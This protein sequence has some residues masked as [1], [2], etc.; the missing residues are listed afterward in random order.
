MPAPRKLP[1]PSEIR[2]LLDDG[3]SYAEI[4]EMYDCPVQSLY[5]IVAD[6]KKWVPE[7][8]PVGWEFLPWWVRPAH[9]QSDTARLLRFAKTLNEEGRLSHSVIERS[10]REQLQR[11]EYNDY[12]ISY[13][14]DTPKSRLEKKGGFFFRPRRDGDSPGLMQVPDESECPPSQDQVDRWAQMFD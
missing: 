6:E 10:V 3:R 4:A 2:R 7:N 14:P 11:L 5:N 1:K 8:N 12:V 9:L 13:H